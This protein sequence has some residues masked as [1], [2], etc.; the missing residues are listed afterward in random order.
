MAGPYRIAVALSVVSPYPNHQEVFAG[1]LR[2]A[3][4]CGNWQC[5]I[6][7]HPMYRPKQ[8]RA[9][10]GEYH[11]VIA[12]ADPQMQRRIRS[13]GVPLVNTLYHH[14]KPGLAG[15]YMDPVAMGRLA[16]EHLIGRGFR[17]FAVFADTSTRQTAEVTATLIHEIEADGYR[18][19]HDSIPDGE[20]QDPEFWV[21]LE[22]TVNAMVDTLQ[23]PVAVFLD[24]AINARMLVELCQHRGLHVP[25][26]VAVLCLRNPERLLDI[27][28]SIS[29]IQDS[30]HQ[31]GY[32]A[33]ALLDRLIRG[34]PVPE[35][36]LL[37]APPGVAVRTS[38]DHFAVE[39]PLVAD[40]LRYIS[41]HLNGPLSVEQIA[42]ELCVSLRTLYNRFESTLGRT[43]GSEIRRLRI[44]SA[45]V[46][47]SDPELTLDQVAKRAGFSSVD[48][49]GR[50]FK[51][52]F[53]MSPGAYRSGHRMS[54]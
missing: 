22:Q 1:V 21:R 45:R 26:D 42:Y 6:D 49:M 12:R 23:P 32:E 13:R 44:N 20:S 34:H 50:V 14:H 52:A 24:S 38:T 53:G 35:K 4:E 51:R 10:R 46:M 5:F 40:A 54:Q 15:V 18:C 25:Q 37:I 43:I 2:Y 33:A 41:K 11:G 8:R 17:R 36:P 16:A 47:L 19:T 27:P 3:R 7:E 9:S 48:V 30:Y 28:T 29:S 31:V 39:D